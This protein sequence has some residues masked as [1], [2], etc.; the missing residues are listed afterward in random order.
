[1]CAHVLVCVWLGVGVRGVE[2]C[3]LCVSIQDNFN[4]VAI[5]Q[6]VT[7]VPGV[8]TASDDLHRL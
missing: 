3:Y 8:A 7:D 6:S 5:G 1:M 4:V 2:Q